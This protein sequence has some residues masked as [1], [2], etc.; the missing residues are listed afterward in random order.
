M[1]LFN[2]ITFDTSKLPPLYKNGIIQIYPKAYV[3][4][5]V[6]SGGTAIFYLTDDNTASGNAMFT[7]VYKESLNWW[8]DDATFQYQIGGYTISSDKKTLTLTVNKLG[9][10]VLGLIQLV[11]AA[12]GVV[13]NLTIWGA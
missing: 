6:V 2:V 1:S 7:G 13:V 11:S 8:I 4:S 12:N 5:A 10:V 3:T 9:T